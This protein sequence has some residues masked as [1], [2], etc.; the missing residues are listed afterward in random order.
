M[1]DWID[2][3]VKCLFIQPGAYITANYVTALP[4]LPTGQLALYQYTSQ[5]TC[6]AATP[7]GLSMATYFP[8]TCSQY[9]GTPGAGTYQ[10]PLCAAN[11]VVTST[12]GGFAILRYY[13]TPTCS[14]LPTATSFYQLNVCGQQANNG[15]TMIVPQVTAM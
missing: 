7:S 10:T 11:S 12:T 13:N 14:S 9:A 4:A 6:S 1:A 8:A 5:A 3:T 15:S 2:T